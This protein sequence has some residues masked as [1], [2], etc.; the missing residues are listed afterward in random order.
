MLPIKK[1]FTTELL[2]KI[3]P[4][5]VTLRLKNLNPLTFL[6]TAL[7]FLVFEN[8]RWSRQIPTPRTAC[9]KGKVPSTQQE[10]PA[11]HHHGEDE[12]PPNSLPSTGNSRLIFI[13]FSFKASPQHQ[14]CGSA[15][16]IM[17]IQ[18]PN[19]VY[20]DLDPRG[21]KTKVEKLHQHFFNL[22]FQYDI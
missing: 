16:F 11:H 1:T 17:R 18:D 4:P 7:R 12:L 20:M 13:S 14:C 19:N 6:F 15:S 21:V 10:P 2:Q 8:H 5:K 3:S 9:W 22:I